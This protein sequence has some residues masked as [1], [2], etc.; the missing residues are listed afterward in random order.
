MLINRR[1]FV[2]GTAALGAAA[3]VT[4]AS[5]AE[6]TY[7]LGHS[8]PAEHPFSIRLTEM[9]AEVMEKTGG[10]MEIQLFPASQL[11]GD[12]DLLSQVR[13]GAVEFFPGAGLI[14]ASVLPVTAIDGMGF[15]FPSY[16]KVWAAVDGDLGKYV[17]DQ[18]RTKTNLVPMDRVW[19]L[20][21]RQI[22]N[23]V[24][25]VVTADDLEGLKLRVPGAPALVSLFQGLGVAP[26]S[27]Q[28]GEVY[29]ALQTKVVDGQENPLATIDAGKFYE[30]QNHLALSNH[31]WNGF[32]M[33]ANGDAWARLPED[34]QQIVNDAFSSKGLLQRQDLV[35]MNVG[36]AD[37][38]KSKGMEITTIDT[39]SF[40][41]KL[42]EAGFYQTWREKI[43]GEAWEIL[44][45][46]AGKLG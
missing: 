8:T 43:G 15:A 4:R 29:T 39:D 5:G 37:S 13:S 11:G 38:L 10:R 16:D 31:V 1:T 6:F 14:L 46:Y 9:A 30:V 20:G 3:F 17:A 28:F 18:I 25:P 44:E 2:G 40:R 42:R 12:N 36:L 33:L 27:M 21:Y 32:W 24:R 19:D 23:S 35:D 41:A 22:T 34:I 26:V 45:S 7:K